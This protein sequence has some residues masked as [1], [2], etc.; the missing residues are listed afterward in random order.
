MDEPDEEYAPQSPDLSA[1]HSS[2]F[3]PQRQHSYYPQR[4]IHQNSINT[5]PGFSSAPPNFKNE[6]P[7]FN[8]DPYNYHNPAYQPYQAQQYPRMPRN[9]SRGTG[10]AEFHGD[11]AEWTPNAM[12]G[13]GTRKGKNPQPEME[14]DYGKPAPGVEEGIKVTTKFPVARIKRIMQADEDV[15]KVA[16]VT[17]TAVS[18]ALELFMISVVTKAANEAKLKSSKRVTAAH[19]KQAVEKD[20]QLDFLAE[21]ISKV[22]DA[23]APKKDEDSEEAV[24][25]KRKKAGTGGGGGTRRRKKWSR[26]IGG[27]SASAVTKQPSLNL[28]ERR[29]ASFKRAYLQLQQIWQKTK[30]RPSPLFGQ[31]ILPHLQTLNHLLQ[32][33]IHTASGHVCLQNVATSQIYILVSSIGSAGIN[34]EATKEAVRFFNFLIDS[35]EVDF[36]QDAAFADRLTSF[37]RGDSRANSITPDAESGM[38]ELLFAVAAKSRQRR[39]IPSAWF[40][41]NHGGE[42]GRSS[43]G[44]VSVSRFQEFSLMYMLLDYVHHEGKS[45]D[46]ARTGLLYILESAARSEELEKWIIDSELATMMA[47]G[48]G[49]LYSQLSSKVALSYSKESLPAILAFS[50]VTNF[51]HPSD[52]EPISSEALQTNLATFLSFLVFWQDALERCPSQEIKA[53]LMDHF[54][55]LFLRPLLYPSLVESSDMDSGSSVAV[56]TYLRAILENLSHSDFIHLILHYMLGAPARLS[57]DSKP[58]RPSTLARRRKSESLINNNAVRIDDPSPELITLTDILRGYLESRNQQTVTACLRLIATMLHFRHE[59][60]DR[61]L[62]KFKLSR[63]STGRR[64]M[65]THYQY[66]ETLYSMAEGISDDD[67]LGQCYESHLEDAQVLLETHPCSADQLLPPDMDA[68]EKDEPRSKVRQRSIIQDDPLLTCL[69]SLLENFLTNDIVVNLSLSE[70][71]A[72]LASCRETS[73]EDWLLASVSDRNVAEEQSA[74]DDHAFD[75]NSQ[76]ASPVFA[77]L[78]LLI[79]RIG[80]LRRDIDDFDIYLAERRHVFKVGGDIDDALAGVSIQEPPQLDNGNPP[81]SKDQ[82]GS[83]SARLKTSD[84]PSRSTSPRGRQKENMKDS[85]AP[86][87]SVVGRLSHLRLSPSPGRVNPGERTYSSSPLRKQSL[88]STASSSIPSPRGPPDALYQRIRLQAR[89]RPARSIHQ[90]NESETSSIRSESIRSGIDSSEETREIGLS[91]LLTNV[92]ILQDFILELA[93][94]LQVRASLF[95]EINS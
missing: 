15:G 67:T 2:S 33:E 47:S 18:K 46:F 93:A 55:F 25:G 91:H 69:L 61:T 14:D 62:M 29:L 59:F 54:D 56:M 27:A 22:P 57:E 95:G 79:Q 8:N 72:A 44:S 37:V 92:I 58:S 13:K 77:R 80:K 43:N 7:N 20:E 10:P 38:V 74:G 11:D 82:I 88:S 87:K 35:E 1:Y 28:P 78:E 64:S 53:T 32:D 30:S 21:I 40:R 41:P 85:T 71:L 86:P 4:P 19:L 34:D 83:I 70:N 65:S 48:L 52:A 84:H 5:P 94:I 31:T 36:I 24:E 26:F 68:L 51:D 12:G 90:H 16:Q 60:A 39:T 81:R 17:P 49:A 45:G 9:G 6:P 76:V 75:K 42:Q 63:E 89:S 3:E 73:L 66:L 23:P 50:D